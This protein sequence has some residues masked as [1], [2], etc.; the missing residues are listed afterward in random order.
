MEEADTVGALNLASSSQVAGPSTSKV[1]DAPGQFSQSR[2]GGGQRYFN[3]GVKSAGIQSVISSQMLKDAGSKSS[4]SQV[5]QP[6]YAVGPESLDILP[7]SSGVPCSSVKSSASQSANVRHYGSSAGPSQASQ[8][9]N[10]SSNQHNV[11]NGQKAKVSSGV[12]G[13]RNSS[14][15][16][17][18]STIELENYSTPPNQIIPDLNEQPSFVRLLNDDVSLKIIFKFL[19]NF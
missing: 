7:S 8:A 19:S 14:G 5:A 18:A 11:G 9:V 13:D 15:T 3:A 2:V 4:I 17:T 1:E 6:S 16:F 12:G 10:P